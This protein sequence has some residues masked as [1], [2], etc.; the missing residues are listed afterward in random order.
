MLRIRL[1]SVLLCLAS[2]PALSADFFGE[3]IVDIKLSLPKGDTY[4]RGA[5]DPVADL[6]AEITLTNLTKKENLAN[7]TVAAPA[8]VQLTPDEIASL[9]KLSVEDRNALVEK[10][11]G[12][13]SFEQRPTN[14]DS[15]GLAYVEPQLGACDTVR[16]VITKL[17]E[18]GEQVPENAKP[19]IAQRDDKPDHIPTVALSPTKYLAAGESSPAFSLPVGK[20]YLVRDPGLYSIK[21]VVRTIG[22]TGKPEK[23]AES[24]EEKF[25]VLP[26]KAM[27]Y[28]IDTLKSEWSFYERGLP[29]FDYQVYQV[30]NPAGFDEVYTVQKMMVRGVATWEWLRLCTVKSGTVAQ[31]AFLAPKK[32]ALMAVHRKDDA[33]LY[34]LDFSGLGLKTTAKMVPLKEGAAPKL[35]V[36]AGAAAVE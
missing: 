5:T 24:N 1:L 30:R 25:R 9:D 3:N 26:F 17:P 23:M 29:T 34:T 20:F 32:F 14:K 2:F 18:E 35:K 33:G 4:V 13:K 28:D 16:F 27:P 11:K 12:T 36:E 10:K 22:N 7:E 31:I 15:L 21:A 8:T 19:V 6:V